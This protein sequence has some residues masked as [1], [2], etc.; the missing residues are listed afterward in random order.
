MNA[1]ILFCGDTHGP[2]TRIIRA[3]QDHP[4]H[5]LIHLGDLSPLG[6]SLESVLPASVRERFWFIPGN[7]DYDQEQYYDQ[8]V[9]S[10]M[11]DRKGDTRSG[12]DAMLDSDKDSRD[13][14]QPVIV[15]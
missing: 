1:K 14:L 7:H 15:V 10:G 6:G 3:A 11:A 8:T 9:G 4:D 12:E 5:Q 2:L 13:L